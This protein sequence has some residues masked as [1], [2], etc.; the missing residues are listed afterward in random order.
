MCDRIIPVSDTY[1]HLLIIE[2][3]IP[4]D[5]G[6]YTA[7]VDGVTTNCTLDVH[8]PTGDTPN[9][10]EGAPFV[11]EVPRQ[12]HAYTGAK[13]NL[14]CELADFIA[15]EGIWL[16]EN[17]QIQPGNGIQMSSDGQRR[18]LLIESAHPEMTG[19]V[20]FMV[21]DAQSCCNLIVSPLEITSR[22]SDVNSILNSRAVIEV[23]F[24][25][26]IDLDG[27]WYKDTTEISQDDKHYSFVKSERWQRLV[28]EETTK[29]DAGLYTYKVES[30]GVEYT[31]ELFVDDPTVPSPVQSVE[32]ELKCMQSP[33]DHMPQVHISTICEDVL[34]IN[35][36]E[37]VTIEFETNEEGLYGAW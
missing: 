16:Y 32:E 29:A 10:L 8:T 17:R 35:E 21:G 12:K 9:A 5:A 20:T 37:G 14:E 4:E 28:I 23:E 34:N 33:L 24:T 13:I 31:A 1:K 30:A 11:A 15:D 25:H 3:V 6:Q 26:E 18:L 36:A 22:V 19:V 7:E 27:V 2:D